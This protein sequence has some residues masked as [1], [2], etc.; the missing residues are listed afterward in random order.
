VHNDASAETARTGGNEPERDEKRK[1][2]LAKAVARNKTEG[3]GTE[4]LSAEISARPP[5]GIV[6]NAG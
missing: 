3:P 6:L 5:P 1:R 2:T 4:I